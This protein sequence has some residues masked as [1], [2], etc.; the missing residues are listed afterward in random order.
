MTLGERRIRTDF[1]PSEIPNVHLA[2]EAAADFIDF[3]EMAVPAG[4]NGEAQRLK[5]LGHT[6]VEQAAMWYVKALTEES[7]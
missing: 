3:M 2:K 5:A 1:N 6:A 4:A 7:E